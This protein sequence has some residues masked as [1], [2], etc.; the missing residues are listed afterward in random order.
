MS[1]GTAPGMR[2]AERTDFVRAFVDQA[3]A[4]PGTERPASRVHVALLVTMG[5][6]AVALVTGVLLQLIW[7]VHLAPAA[8]HPSASPSAPASYLAVTG[9]DCGS[10]PDR[11]FDLTG[12]T[13]AWYTVASGGWA[14]GGCHG[15][16]EAI[17]LSGDP[18]R[19]DQGQSAAWWFAPDSAIKRCELAVYLPV[20]PAAGDAG[21]TTAQYTV[22]SG[23][24]GGTVATFTVDQTVR[25]GSWYVLGRFPVG[26]GGIAVRLVNAG[27]PAAPADRLAVTQA[28]ASCTGE[29]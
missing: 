18:T 4:R 25:P 3:W 12:R 8:A 22:L 29:V 13:P 24:S 7:P 15:T 9:W 11:G 26:T 6:M 20:P 19:A 10:G 14:G 21:A 2:V 17:P 5:S 28:R 16:F 27:V 1:D 23:R